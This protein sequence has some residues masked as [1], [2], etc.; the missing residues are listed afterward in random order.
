MLVGYFILGQS[1]LFRLTKQNSKVVTNVQTLG[2][3][4][5]QNFED[6]MKHTIDIEEIR[7]GDN[8]SNGRSNNRRSCGNT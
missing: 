3:E 2:G 6:Q 4:A 8:R 1:E 7:G 5:T